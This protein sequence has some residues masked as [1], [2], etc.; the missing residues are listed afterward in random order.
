MAKRISI[1]NF[2][3]G[4]GKTTLAFHLAAGLA[5]F[6]EGKKILLVD[7]DHQSSLSVLC[8]GPTGWENV[9]TM[10]QTVDNVFRHFM[11][12]SN[13]FPGNE[14]IDRRPKTKVWSKLDFVHSTGV[15]S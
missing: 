8:E 7:V 11:D 4:V 2:K 1:I 3:G 13:S 14:I 9:V 5:R 6:F 12:A 10:S 15:A